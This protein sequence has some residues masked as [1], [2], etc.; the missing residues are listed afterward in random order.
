VIEKV[1]KKSLVNL[2]Q[3]KKEIK[4]TIQNLFVEK[5]L[6]SFIIRHNF[7]VN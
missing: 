1:G 4:K 6:I 7:F 2:N 3:K 5:K